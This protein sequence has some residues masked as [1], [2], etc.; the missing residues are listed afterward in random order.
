MNSP[1]IIVVGAGASGLACAVS[2]AGLGASVSVL[3]AGTRPG[4]SIMASGN[5]RC[6]FCNADLSPRRYNDPAFVARS[7]TG[8]V[9][10]EVLGFFESLG[11]WH[12]C[13]E[14]G[15]YY[16]RTRCAAS[17]LDVLLNRAEELGV[18][19]WAESRVAG[20]RRAGG[21]WEAA[22]EDGRTFHADKVVWC[23]GGQSS[24]DFAR[25]ARLDLV[26]T[27]RVLCPIATAPKPAKDLDGVRLVCELAVERAGRVVFRAPGEV[28][29]RKYGLSGIVV[30][31]ASRHAEPGDALALDLVPHMGLDALERELARRAAAAEGATEVR[32]SRLRLL[33][34]ALQPK[35]AAHLM[36]RHC[37]RDG[38][39]R[40]EAGRLARA[41]KRWEFEVAQVMEG[42]QA[43]VT[44]GGIANGQ[45]NPETFEA[46]GREGLFVCGEALDV[47]G[48]CGGLNLA[49]AWHSGILAGRASAVE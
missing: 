17:V 43:Q 36:E 8:D 35:L 47:D 10:G 21:Q 48:M 1:R 45:V 30:F 11:L 34:G 14:E 3:E 27:R 29:L 31:D 13:D 20:L 44:R 33:D 39:R 15:R 19:I 26:P 41:L 38:S 6:N 28:L 9:A 40:V 22:V 12:V 46:R 42:D 23:A 2:A 37:G 49:W 32:L 7:Y 18:R 5:G 16:P 25:M 4:R 24:A